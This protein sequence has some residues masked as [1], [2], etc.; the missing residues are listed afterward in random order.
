MKRRGVEFRGLLYAGLMVSL[1]HDRGD[2]QFWVL[3]FNARFGDPE[4]QVLLPRIQGDLLPWCLASARG[5]LSALPQSVPFK[6]ESAV[7]VVA[8]AKGYPE[9]PQTGR[10]VLVEHAEGESNSLFFGGVRSGAKAGDCKG[11]P[12]LVT[13]GGR[14][15]GALGTGDSLEEA[16][17]AAYR[18]LSK[19]QFEGMQ[20]R[21]D[22]ASSRT[23]IVIFA[24]GRGSN[25]DALHKA[26]EEKQLAAD[27]LAVISD[28]PE[29]LVLEKARKV[30][31][32]A[33]AIPFQGGQS[34]AEHER[35][36]VEALKPFQPKFLAV[37]GYMRIVTDLLIEAFRSEK[38]YA[39]IVNIHPSL[40]PA[41]PGLNAYEQAFHAG[42]K[43]AGATVH[44]VEKE[45]DSGPICAQEVFSIEECRSV[46]ESMPRCPGAPA[47]A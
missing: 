15:L 46:S 38:G 12:E 13:S 45:V 23:G 24:S 37:A 16:R 41:F 42:V 14:V 35:K 44:L 22:I 4:A 17:V 30:G 7:F 43:F 20:F 8:A 31:I 2:G 34:R 1:S 6:K 26:V 19:V 27:I 33:V 32:P 39:R 9:Q 21:P 11:D 47:T 28:N 25:F 36:I 40:L 18:H 5:D 29:A 10:R 3:E